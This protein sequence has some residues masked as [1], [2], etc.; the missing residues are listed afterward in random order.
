[1]ARTIQ[2]IYDVMIA[3][4][5][6]MAELNAL[7]PNIDSSQTLLTDLTSASRVAIWRLLFF[8]VAVAIWTNEKLFDELKAW[9]EIRLSEQRIGNLKWYQK[10]ALE[11]Q[12]GDMLVMI[13]DTYKYVTTN[14]TNQIVK[15]ASVNE[16]GGQ[17]L[18]KVANLSAGTP[19][20]LSTPE[21]QAFQ[22]YLNKIKVAG[23]LVNALSRN[24]DSLKIHYKIYYDPLV[25][26]PSGE[27]IS[28]PGI[29]PVEDAIN[30]YCKGLDFDGVFVTTYLTDKIQKAIG[31]INPVFQTGEVK[32]GSN[33][34]TVLGDKYNPNAGYL[35]VDP[36]YPLSTTITYIQA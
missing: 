6:T 19:V 22:N 31:V 5:Q 29:F 32:Y 30:N 21:L 34:Y 12:Y 35:E 26:T 7:Q 17:V 36:A 25:L 18:V 3:E 9:I 2:E 33:P 28:T 1:M 20:P 16:V 27:L 23:V 14:I 4:K 8:V 10:K 24:A 15:L 13:D 11:F